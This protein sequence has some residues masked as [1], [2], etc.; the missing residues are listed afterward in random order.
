MKLRGPSRAVSAA[1]A[2]RQSYSSRLTSPVNPLDKT[3]QEVP[4]LKY[5]RGTTR[6][7]RWGWHPGYMRQVKRMS[8]PTVK[9]DPWKKGLKPRRRH[10]LWH[11]SFWK[12]LKENAF[13]GGIC[14]PFR[15]GILEMIS[16]MNERL[17]GHR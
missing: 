16:E 7:Q 9:S 5:K 1:D 12:R 3:K 13:D 15:G 2:G 10:L 8:F 11:N 6:V 4:S 14:S 17:Y